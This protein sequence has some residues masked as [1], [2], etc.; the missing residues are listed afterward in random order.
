VT[1]IEQA[2]LDVGRSLEIPEAPDLT[3]VVLARLEGQRP[4]KR[5]RRAWALAVAVGVLAA[6]A[7]IL[8]IPPARSALLRVLHLGSERIELVDALPSVPAESNLEAFLGT[9]VSLAEARRT[10]GFPLR[11][12]A[13]APDA[14]YRGPTGTIWYLYGTP[15]HVRLLVAQTP[16][17]AV[18]RGLTI[19]KLAGPGTRV[20]EVSVAGSPGLFLSGEPHIV[21]L[22][23]A[24]G[25]TIA[26]SVR[27][28][29]NVLVWD[30]GGVTYRL[31]GDFTHDEALD[32]ARS[33]R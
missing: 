3:A 18:E 1:E 8:V 33:L 12:L 31:E 17:L 6:L 16:R 27:L 23:D 10:A 9:P 5:V 2:L 21:L 28:A 32:L 20:E 15:E 19:K 26:D 14:V 11:T 24:E 4:V 13:E 7:A 22:E 29:R 30:T 25:N